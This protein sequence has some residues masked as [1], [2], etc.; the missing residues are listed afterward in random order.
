MQAKRFVAH[1]GCLI[2]P[3]GENTVRKDM[4]CHN[5]LIYSG[6]IHRS[7][8]GL[9]E[10]TMHLPMN[11]LHNNILESIAVLVGPKVFRP[12]RL[13]RSGKRCPSCPT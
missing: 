11:V 3:F 7:V 8:L 1:S 6:N 13:N 12:A 5:N 10:L 9:T 2:Q 4:L